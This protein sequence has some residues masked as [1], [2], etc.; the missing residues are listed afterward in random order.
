M[1]VTKVEIRTIGKSPQELI[2]LALRQ[3]ADGWTYEV[4]DLNT[5]PLALPWRTDT[6]HEAEVKLNATYDSSIWEIRVVEEG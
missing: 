3:Y 4:Q 2:V 1:T 6:M 5:G